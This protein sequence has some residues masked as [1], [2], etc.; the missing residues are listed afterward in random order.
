MCTDFL[1]ISSRHLQYF[2][3]D[4]PSTVSSK[5]AAAE[6]DGNLAV[7]VQNLPKDLMGPLQ[8]LTSPPY[9][10]ACGLVTRDKTSLTIVFFQC[11]EK[12]QFKGHLL[13]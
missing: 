3:L 4:F 1:P 10:C 11:L 13:I 5:T 8:Y 7:T 9:A 6:V 12:A 2:P